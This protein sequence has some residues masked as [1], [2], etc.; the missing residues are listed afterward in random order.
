MA[1]KFQQETFG[2]MFDCIEAEPLQLQLVAYPDT[3]I[4]DI[5]SYFWM[6]EVDVGEHEVVIVG[7]FRIYVFS[8]FLVIA[9]NLVDGALLIRGIVVRAGEVIPMIFLS[10]VFLIPG[11]EVESKPAFYLIGIG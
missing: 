4:L 1:D 7:V 9:Q 8:P 3:P 5:F 11:S 2:E 6:G 10:R